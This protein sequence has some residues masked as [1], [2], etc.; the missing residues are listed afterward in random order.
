MHA[1]SGV[2]NGRIAQLN[3]H[4]EPTSNVF[5]PEKFHIAIMYILEPYWSDIVA[6][7][8]TEDICPVRDGFS[9]VKQPALVSGQPHRYIIRAVLQ[10]EVRGTTD[11]NARPLLD[12]RFCRSLTCPDLQVNRMRKCSKCKQAAYCSPECQ[13]AHWPLHK[14]QC[15]A[16]AA[17]SSTA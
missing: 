1:L 5:R 6:V 3:G 10:A 7:L 15:V 2:S 9:V 11:A 4:L 12:Y 14:R 17:V 13:K 8:D 16:A